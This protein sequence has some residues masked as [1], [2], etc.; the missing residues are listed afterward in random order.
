[1]WLKQPGLW[2]QHFVICD[3]LLSPVVK[4]GSDCLLVPEFPLT[5]A[6]TV[7]ITLRANGQQD[8][9]FLSVLL[10]Q[11]WVVQSRKRWMCGGWREETGE[12]GRRERVGRWTEKG[13]KRRRGGRG[14]VEA[15]KW[16]EKGQSTTKVRMRN[17]N[18]NRPMC[19]AVADRTEQ[20]TVLYFT[21]PLPLTANILKK[22][23][24]MMYLQQHG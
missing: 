7:T 1:M 17:G 19:G 5:I 2:V 6:V 24:F 12:G 20:L 16:R 9:R 14:Y 22:T 3:K 15:M 21:G 11:L 23:P 4:L 10:I 18:D 8:R 13:R